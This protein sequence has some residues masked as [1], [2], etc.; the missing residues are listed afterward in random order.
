MVASDYSLQTYFNDIANFVA[1]APANVIGIDIFNEP[2]QLYWFQENTATTPTQPAWIT[3]IAA[4]ASAVY[5]NNRNVLLFVEAPG[6][7]QGN[8]PFDPIFSQT[9]PICIPTSTVIHNN[10]N[11][12]VANN[13]KLCPTTNTEQMVYLGSNWGENFRSLLDTTQSAKGVAKFNVT[14]FRSMLTQSITA[15]HFSNTDPNVIA[16]WILGANND[17]NGGHI[18]I[19]APH[20]YG[21]L[22]AGWQ[23]DANDS[24]IRFL[25]N[26]GFLNNSGFPF[27]VGELGYDVVSG[28]EDF[29]LD[30]VAPWLISHN[31]PSN[32]FF[33]TWNNSDSPPGIRA[34]DS[35]YALFAWKEQDLHNLFNSTPTVQKFGTLC[36]TVP[37]P[38]GYIGTAFPVII[39]TG[40]SAY[41]VNLSHF[42]QA[43]CVNNV[44]V[45]NY[46]LS[47]N[48]IKNPNGISYAPTST[49]TATITQN[50]TTNVTINYAVQ[51]TGTLQAAVTGVTQCPI[52]ATQ[53]FIVSYTG[54]T[55][56]KITV[57]GTTPASAILPVGTYTISVTPATL[58]SNSQCNATYNNTVNITANATVQENI[59][60]TFTPP[61][62]CT[63]T[64]QCS[65]WGT[66][67]DPWSGSSCNFAISQP[68]GLT[69]PTVIKMTTSGITAITG[70]WNA[71][72]TFANGQVTTQ[73]SDAVH[74]P[75]FGFNASGIITVPTS[76]TLTSNG[77]TYNCKV[78]STV[79]KAKKIK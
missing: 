52:S 32:L 55:S 59:K 5:D 18:S 15:N 27:V 78:T 24:L 31:S 76:A 41:T 51:P 58:P 35:S 39:A 8:D 33:W 63:M 3:V 66:P 71:A 49:P 7:T 2:H 47:G 74:I 21:S 73:L 29:F 13:P 6:G 36:V 12:G 20:L 70:S 16:D 30:S 14:L 48:M 62:A 45:G 75:S 72:T 68:T 46:S 38:A 64:A 9:N 42:G 26:F 23:T 19:F 22:V 54:A 25:W 44:L 65:T 4:A 79:I 67:S 10:A 60:Y 50:A 77:Q 17:G 57:T 40:P 61:A 53:K 28:G 43:T 37:P 34:S 69:N 1:S 11:I 56:N